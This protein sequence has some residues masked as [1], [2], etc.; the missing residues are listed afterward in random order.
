MGAKKIFNTRLLTDVH[1][2]QIKGERLQ[3][4][5]ADL[6]LKYG[7]LKTQLSRWRTA[8][9]PE[10]ELTGVLEKLDALESRLEKIESKLWRAKE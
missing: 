2:R 8:N 3:D 6:E 9:I 10:H 5:A 4:I 1:R 7:S